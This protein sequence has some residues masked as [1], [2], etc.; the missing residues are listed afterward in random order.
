MVKGKGKAMSKVSRKCRL[1]CGDRVV[2]LTGKD[3]GR[4]GIITRLF[5][6]TRKFRADRMMAVVEGIN[7][8]KKHKRAR[9]AED[10]GGI[11]EQ[12]AAI[13]VSNI[14]YLN[15]QSNKA[16]RIGYKV[17]EDGKKVRVTKSDNEV[18]DG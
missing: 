12:E 16:D 7:M 3:K 5:V 17:L 18:I 11:V 9:S 15:P 1:K 6:R 4:S 2:V 13:D 14:A 10:E 8:N